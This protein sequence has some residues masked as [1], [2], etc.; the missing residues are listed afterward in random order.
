[1]YHNVKNDMQRMV[2]YFNSLKVPYKLE[3]VNDQYVKASW[4][5]MDATYFTGVSITKEIQN[6][7]VYIKLDDNGTF[8][9]FDNSDSLIAI[10]GASNSRRGT[11]ATAQSFY[12]KQWRFE[13]TVVLGKDNIDSE[14]GI[15]SFKLNS[16]SIH[17]ALKYWLNQ[18]GYKQ[19]GATFKE[20]IEGLRMSVNP[21][22]ATMV[23][24]V[25]TI[26]GIPMEC[27]GI[28]HFLLGLSG[29]SVEMQIAIGGDPMQTVNDPV[30]TM[31]F[32]MAFGGFAL[33]PLMI[34]LVMLSIHLPVLL[35]TLKEN[36][37]NEEKYKNISGG[38]RNV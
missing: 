35:K 33:I 15:T 37:E 5:W 26:G 7:A 1:M 9:W 6:F 13:K 19:R 38:I 20:H 31:K 3:I 4:R 32:G 30:T 34:G 8:R 16:A 2:E 29:K 11:V 36:K 12:G 21:L 28:Y 25:F 23:G 27:V 22:I 14:V 18:N 17:K 24:G 10:P